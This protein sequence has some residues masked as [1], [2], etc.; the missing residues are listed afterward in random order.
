[1]SD[2]L[3]EAHLHEVLYKHGTRV[4]AGSLRTYINEFLPAEYRVEVA[5]YDR[6]RDRVPPR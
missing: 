1:M 6:E 4:D 3:L 2:R 5:S